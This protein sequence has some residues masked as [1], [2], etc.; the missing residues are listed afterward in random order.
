VDR[1]PSRGESQGCDN[2]DRME[3]ARLDE[4][5][6]VTVAPAVIERTMKAL[7]VYGSHRSKALSFGLARWNWASEV[8]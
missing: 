7:R 1:S 8:S 4:I 2:F 3:V 5:R 6:S